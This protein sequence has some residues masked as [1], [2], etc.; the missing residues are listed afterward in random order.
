MKKHS[1]LVLS[2]LTA[3]VSC[4]ND[5]GGSPMGT[6]GAGGQ[7]G[8]VASAGAGAGGM[9][10]LAGNAGVPAVTAG[11]AGTAGTGGA[12]GTCE[13]PSLEVFSRSDT[14]QAWD[15]NDFSAVVLGSEPCPKTATVTWPHE[16][17]WENADP[18]EANSEVTHFTLDSYSSVDLTNKKLS[19]TIELSA[20]Q[21]GAGATAGS[22]S[23]SLVSVS[24]F[25]RVVM[26]GGA[27]TDA[28]GSGG[29]AALAGGGGSA[30]KGGGGGASG[31]DASAGGSVSGGDGT[32]G[33]PVTTDTGYTEA[34]LPVADR[35]T[36]RFVGDRATV[37]FPLP[38]KTTEL[39]SYDPTRVI[40]INV[41]IYNTFSSGQTGGAGG[42]GGA[43]GTAGGA[44]MGG[45]GGTAGTAGR[46]GGGGTA[47][48]AGTSGGGG[49]SGGT[50]GLVGAS[51]GAGGSGG[52]STVG[53]V[54]NYGTS[55]FSITSFVIKDVSAP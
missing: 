34:E 44:G 28:G 25:D 16:T 30:G 45:G 33:A 22:Y 31:T 5:D 12:G 40:K 37:I 8:A 41:R 26:M 29:L 32:A 6:S 54:Y 51:G 4:G 15:D 2:L 47:G 49:A 13:I 36:L 38:N 11:S 24:T 21:R 10:A 48:L 35:A 43:G 23:I 39:G 46:G 52:A 55:T 3:I 7:A 50:A 1:V 14:D 9:S 19:L 17:G 53:P 18:A 42:A 27:G 20:D